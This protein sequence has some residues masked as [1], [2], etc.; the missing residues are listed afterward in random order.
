[1][2]LRSYAN[3]KNLYFFSAFYISSKSKCEEKNFESKL[4]HKYHL[5]TYEI[6][7]NFF[8]GG[9]RTHPKSVFTNGR[10]YFTFLI[11]SLLVKEKIMNIIIQYM[12]IRKKK[13]DFR[14]SIRKHANN[15]C[16]QQ[17]KC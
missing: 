7:S 6:T 9:K 1:M 5:S 4:T 16:I 17:P 10:Y 13:Y 3:K 15:D 2:V 12:K 14:K 11:S 8:L